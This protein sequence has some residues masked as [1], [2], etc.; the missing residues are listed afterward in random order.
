MHRYFSTSCASLSEFSTT[1]KYETPAGVSATTAR[2]FNNYTRG[3]NQVLVD[4]GKTAMYFT[5]EKSALRESLA[6]N[7][8]GTTTRLVGSSLEMFGNPKEATEVIGFDVSCQ[9]STMTAFV[10]P[11]QA[12][13]DG[14]SL[15][16]SKDGYT[17]RLNAHGFVGNEASLAASSPRFKQLVFNAEHGE[18]RCSGP[19]RSRAALTYVGGLGE[20]VLAR[21]TR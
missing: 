20:Q 9:Q 16:A 3:A 21:W 17:V 11:Y 18:S 7:D 2:I 10:P 13:P 4:S 5:F 14:D 8:D 12:D 19:L 6:A 15:E 1:V